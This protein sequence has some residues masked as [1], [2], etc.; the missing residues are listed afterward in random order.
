M[1][2]FEDLTGMGAGV[3]PRGFDGHRRRSLMAVVGDA[4]HL[5]MFARPPGRA[6]GRV[7]IRRRPMAFWPG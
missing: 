4:E 7:E 2:A 6:F 3:Y 1:G 5:M